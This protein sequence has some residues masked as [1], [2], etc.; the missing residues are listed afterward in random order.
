MKNCLR[1]PSSQNYTKVLPKLLFLFSL[2]VS[3]ATTYY[4]T[5]HI[6]DSDASSELVLAKQLFESGK[7]IS[8]DWFYSTELRVLNAQLIYST[9]FRFFS[10][11][12]LIRF[13]SALTLQAVYILSYGFM[14]H[15]GGFKKS[16]FYISASLLLL[17]VSVAYG[18]IILYHCHYIVHV[19]LSF[20]L[21]GLLLGF[22]RDTALSVVQSCIRIGIILIASFIG[23]LGG[24]RHLMIIHT[25]M[26]L[27]ILLIC[28]LED[29]Q[30]GD[31]SKAA[32]FSR[33][34]ITLFSVAALA[35]VAAYLG[36][37]INT[38]VFPD[39][40]I[41]R[42]YSETNL[43][44]PAFPL[45]SDILYGFL[46]Q[47][48]FRN[49][50]PMLSLVGILSLGG[51]LSAVFCLYLSA[52]II[53][54]FQA[55]K[56]IRKTMVYLFF[57]CFLV[58]M[59]TVFLITKDLYGY[60]YPLYYVICLPWATPLLLSIPNFFS[61]DVHPFNFKRIFSWIAVLFLFANGFANIAFFNGVE[62][63]DQRYEGLTF[64]EKNKVEQLTPVV[65]YLLEN[66]YDYGYGTYWE[67][68][69]TA[70]LTDGKI[71]MFNIFMVTEESGTPYVSYFNWLTSV[72]Q[73]EAPKEKPFLIIS[74]DKQALFE[75]TI[76]YAYCS[77]VYS[78]DFHLVYD[79]DNL[80]EFSKTLDS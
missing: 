44:S 11:W 55:G 52:R 80:E 67:S 68:N 76:N 20:F 54:S 15:Q 7:I 51:I 78:D 53:R 60:Y 25:P 6:L 33:Q 4:V 10:D 27:L 14:L 59:T 28:L 37:K 24:I 17:P 56:D 57:F 22:A 46:H 29:L 72:W 13:F 16:D 39:Y 79:I 23:G 64:Q 3:I 43:A 40:Y 48:G 66:G 35:F 50:I 75:Q 41:F 30:N 65:D 69:I 49:E 62:A 61:R 5:G 73:R 71:P 21:M 70:E 12:H 45:F 19:C 63:F 18:R 74:T 31:S 36:Y 47:F 9:M 1:L 42:S 34:K 32:L 58:V 8:A 38:D 2:I 26:L 77:C